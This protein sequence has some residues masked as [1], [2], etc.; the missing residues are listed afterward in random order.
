MADSD[1]VVFPDEVADEKAKAAEAQGATGG[2]KNSVEEAPEEV[3]PNP[4]IAMRNVI[5]APYNCPPGY[6]MGADGVCREVF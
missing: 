6:T 2:D 5:Q 4:N 1:R 3:T